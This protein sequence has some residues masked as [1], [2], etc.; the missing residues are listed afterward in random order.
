MLRNTSLRY[1]SERE[2]ANEVLKE[3]QSLPIVATDIFFSEIDEHRHKPVFLLSGTDKTHYIF[4]LR[5]TGFEVCEEFFGLKSLKVMSSAYEK[6][7]NLYS[8]KEIWIEN[9]TDIVLLEQL[10]TNSYFSVSEIKSLDDLCKK[11]L[12]LKIEKGK[13]ILLDNVEGE[14]GEQTLEFLRIELLAIFRI[15][16]EQVK[17]IKGLRLER[18]S[19]LESNATRAFARLQQRGI[20][21]DTKGFLALFSGVGTREL[22]SSDVL[23][24]E[25]EIARLFL[26]RDTIAGRLSTLLSD[27]SK[28]YKDPAHTLCLSANELLKRINPQTSRI[29]SRFI[30]ISSASGRSSSQSPNLFAI[31]KSRIFRDYFRAPEGRL[32][33]TLDYSTFELGVLAALSKD[34]HFLRAFKENIDLHSYVAELIFGKKVSKTENPELRRQAKAINFGIVYGMTAAGISKRLNISRTDASRL[35]NKYYMVFPA[36]NAYFQNQSIEAL[37]KQELRTLSG[38]RCSLNPFELEMNESKK[39]VLEYIRKYVG[40]KKGETY[41]ML[42]LKS[43]EENI[44]KKEKY[45]DDMYVKKIINTLEENRGIPTNTLRE[46]DFKIQELYRFARNMPI[47]GTAADIMKKAITDIDERFYKNG[48]DAFIVNIVHDEIVIESEEKIAIE[49][50]TI[51]KEIMEEASKF[52]LKE[53][54][55]GVECN[56]GYYWG[57]SSENHRLQNE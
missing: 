45:T 44:F 21:F 13:R 52:F 38:R 2:E 7:V 40:N 31:P 48:L 53:I 17:R 12:E 14:V 5:R 34:P 37:N 39:K 54:T 29:H 57:D 36:L 25:E 42:L 11:Y 19:R 4:D 56:L 23:F 30:Q 55:V 24:D 26:K 43:I 28:N 10:I 20:Y 41:T 49:V 32:I 16:L 1:C 46:I 8:H 47:Q 22:L 18:V 35:L 9:V 50:A 51:A 6:I 27:F 15:F 33:I 3:I